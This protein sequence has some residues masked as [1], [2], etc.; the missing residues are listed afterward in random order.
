MAVAAVWA[1]EAFAY[2]LLTA[3][4]IAGFQVALLPTGRRRELGRWAAQLAG[5]IVVAHLL[6]A[7]G[8][9]AA[10]EE[11]PDWS[12]YLN[13]LRQFLFGDLGDW[14]YDFSSFSPGLA[15]GAAYLASGSALAVTVMR[16]PDLVREE[17]PLLI[18]IAGMTGYGIALY[19]YI[20][21]RGADHIIPYVSLPR[22]GPRCPVAHARGPP[23]ARRPRHRPAGRARE[24][25]GR[26]GAA[27][28][29]GMVDRR[30]P[31]P[32]VGAR[33]RRARGESLAAARE[34]LWNPAPIRPEAAAGADLL[35]EHLPGESRSIVL[36]SADLSVEILMR[37]ER[38]SEVPLGDPWEDSFVPEQHLDPLQEFVDGLSGGE[39]MLLDAPAR[40]A[41]DG[42]RAQ[43]DLD[44]LAE[45]GQGLI[46]PG[47]MASLQEW[48]LK[49]IGARYDLQTIVVTDEG[50]EVVQLVPRAAG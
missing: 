22:S 43:P 27:R 4:V 49:E 40:R 37:A 50:L 15:V 6:L 34:R 1:L 17:R 14:T 23:R 8:T 33:A 26:L 25:P 36:T 2:T 16:R 28:G 32:P 42:H 20:V 9:L 10:T 45:S 46:E 38:G 21:N 41:F 7:A 44:P 12:W 29:D 24:R 31:L 48:V 39:R 47:A 3:L 35:A 13:T 19:T 30:G 5:A 11:L 18:G